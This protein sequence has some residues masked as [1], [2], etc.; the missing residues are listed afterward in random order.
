[1]S[2]LHFLDFFYARGLL[3]QNLQETQRLFSSQIGHPIFAATIS[4]NKYCFLRSMIV[5]DDAASR[6]ER[7]KTDRFA[8]FRDIFEKFS[9]NCAKKMSPDDFLATDETLY[10]TRGGV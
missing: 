4:Y 2:Y 9:N 1:M 8:A 6:S 3:N 10:P 7:W 5:S